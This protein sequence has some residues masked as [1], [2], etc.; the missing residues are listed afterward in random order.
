MNFQTR[1]RART[2]HYGPLCVGI[3]PSSSM[4]EECGLPNTSEGALSL[5]LRLLEGSK[6]RLSIVKPQMAY[7]ERFGARGMLALETMCLRFAEAQVMILLDG[8]RGDID[9]TA[10]A[11]A[12]AYL[13]P[14]SSYQADALT[15]HAYLGVDAL[16]PFFEVAHENN[17]GLFVVVRSSNSEG[18]ALQSARVDAH[19]T[20]AKHMATQL[21]SWNRGFSSALIGAVIGAT[22]DDAAELSE[23]L[24][25]AWLLAPGVGA[26]GASFADVR[27]RFGAASRRV[28]PSI[29]RAAFKGGGSIQ[30]IGSR[31]LELAQQAQD[32]LS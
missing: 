22:Q 13:S 8:K 23:S 17:K 1:L 16:R 2:Q 25:E 29:S 18:N 24:P 3:D 10:A 28:L 19:T 7:F 31:V 11:Y 5:G 27:A 20:V 14:V 30:A 6:G 32:L 4:L 9:A 15:L 26:Q 21:Q 12:E